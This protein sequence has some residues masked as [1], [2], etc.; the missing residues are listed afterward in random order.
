MQGSHQTDGKHH[1]DWLLTNRLPIKL[2]E[3]DRQA[4]R[5][6]VYEKSHN[7]IWLVWLDL[8]IWSATLQQNQIDTN[9]SEKNRTYSTPT[10]LVLKRYAQKL[11]GSYWK[12]CSFSFTK[13]YFTASQNSN[14]PEHATQD[15]I[16]DF[17]DSNWTRDPWKR[18]QHQTITDIKHDPQ[19]TPPEN[20]PGIR[21]SS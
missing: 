10:L 17:F 9:K 11:W 6:A 20:D 4:D 7:L 21:G 13:I 16:Y 3:T 12:S 18:L 19:L 14:Q 2:Q 15:L 5:W 8:L 1:Q